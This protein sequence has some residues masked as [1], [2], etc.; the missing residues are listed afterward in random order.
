MVQHSGSIHSIA[1]AAEVLNLVEDNDSK[2]Y[3]G[4]DLLWGSPG[5]TLAYP[6]N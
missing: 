2:F 1:G 6:T 4:I 3:R 5:I